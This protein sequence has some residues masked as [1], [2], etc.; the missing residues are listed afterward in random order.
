MANLRPVKLSTDCAEI[1]TKMETN[2]KIEKT[3]LDRQ[4]ISEMTGLALGGNANSEFNELAMKDIELI[5]DYQAKGCYPQFNAN[6]VYNKYLND[7]TK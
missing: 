1:K 5:F 3:I 2:V 6:D 4:K 7:S